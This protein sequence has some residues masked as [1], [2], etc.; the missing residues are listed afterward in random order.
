MGL[1]VPRKVPPALVL[2]VEVT[3]A[4]Q[5]QFVILDRERVR[6]GVGA[7]PVKGWIVN[8]GKE[9][10]EGIDY[11]RRVL[12]MHVFCSGTLQVREIERDRGYGAHQTLEFGIADLLLLLLLL[13]L[14]YILSVEAATAAIAAVWI[15]SKF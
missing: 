4:S 10:E 6:G 14:L 13:F 15:V 9:E 11:V 5:Q 3:F 12:I 1:A 7:A 8:K 2:V